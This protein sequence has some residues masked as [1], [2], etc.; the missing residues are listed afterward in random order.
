MNYSL[1]PALDFIKRT[2][3]VL[4]ALTT[5]AHAAIPSY[6]VVWNGPSR[7]SLDSMPLSG[8]L[9]AGANVWVQDKSIWPYLAHSGA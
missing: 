8:R 9:D 2:F 1:V 4:L 3:L 5:G 7:D 6:K